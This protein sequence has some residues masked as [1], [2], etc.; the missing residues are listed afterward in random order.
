MA[1]GRSETS[2]QKRVARFVVVT[3][4]SGA[5]KSA[6]IRALEDLGYLCVD[7]LPTVLILTLADLTLG[8]GAIYDAVAVVVDARDR[9]FLDHFSAVLKSLRARRDL[10]TSLIFLEASDAALLRRFSETRRPHPLAPT[11]SVIE[12]ILAERARLRRIKK[13]ADR[14]LDTSDLTVHELRRAFRELSQADGK[15]TRLTVTLLSFGYKYGIPSESDLL[16][17]VRFLPNPYFV[18]GLRALTGKD[19]A[20]RDY[21]V[22]AEA[23]EPFLQMTTDLLKFLIPKYTTEGKS[24]LTIGVGCTGGRHRSVAV[25]EQLKPRLAGIAGVRW[26]MRHRDIAVE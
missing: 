1:T 25:V 2:N 17:D 10:G 11:G 5:G 4:L 24:Y 8:K 9:S 13:M 3:G 21:V 7:N 6:A 12:G 26:R 22:A 16:F 19:P 20:V 14:V 18:T 23:T 15:Q